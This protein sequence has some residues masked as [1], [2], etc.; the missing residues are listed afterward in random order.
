MNVIKSKFYYYTK[1][2][3]DRYIRAQVACDFSHWMFCCKLHLCLYK[4]QMSV[5]WFRILITTNILLTKKE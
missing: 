4:N 5:Y 2:F 1:C 3:T